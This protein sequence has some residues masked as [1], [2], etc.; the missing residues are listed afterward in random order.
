[1]IRALSEHLPVMI[2]PRWV[3]V[4]AQPIGIQ[5]LLAYMVEALDVSVEHSL[6]VEIGGQDRLSYGAL[7]RG[8]HA[9]VACGGG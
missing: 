9:S 6:V 2:T 4:L 5:D 1:M 3:S 8:T 7:M